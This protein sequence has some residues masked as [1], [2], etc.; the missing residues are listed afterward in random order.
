MFDDGADLVG[1]SDI[2][3]QSGLTQ[4]ESALFTGYSIA[5]ICPKYTDLVGG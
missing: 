2:L 1:V 5:M 4:G 3:V